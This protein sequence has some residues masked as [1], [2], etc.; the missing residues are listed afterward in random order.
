MAT[1]S[2]SEVTFC[3]TD[4]ESMWGTNIAF[5]TLVRVLRY[6]KTAVDTSVFRVWVV[7]EGR[8]TH[9]VPYARFCE[10]AGV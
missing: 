5:T 6:L 10:L 8:V 9:V 2:T 3:V 7:Q 4:D 1:V